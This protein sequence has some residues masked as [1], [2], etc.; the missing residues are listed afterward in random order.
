MTN[1]FAL[2]KMLMAMLGSQDFVDR[3]WQSQNVAFD[4]KTP[5]DVYLS[6]LEGRRKITSYIISFLD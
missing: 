5:D 6:G 4:M 1:K 2:N 3:W